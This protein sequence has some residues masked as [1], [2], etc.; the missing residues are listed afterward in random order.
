M[1]SGGEVIEE[2]EVTTGA[3]HGLKLGKG[4]KVVEEPCNRSLESTSMSSPLAQVG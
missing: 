4:G 2:P 1:V 3:Y